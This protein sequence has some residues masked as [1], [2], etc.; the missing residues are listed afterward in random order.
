MS[1]RALG[2]VW[3]YP[4]NSL[5]KGFIDGKLHFY[6]TGKGTG[7]TSEEGSIREPFKSSK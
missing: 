4:Q 3:Q 1:S 7:L 6:L 2:A 5:Q